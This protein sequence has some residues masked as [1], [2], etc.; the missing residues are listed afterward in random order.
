MK[1]IAAV[2]ACLLAAWV[3]VREDALPAQHVHA[4]DPGAHTHAQHEHGGETHTHHHSAVDA[5]LA[6]HF[7]APSSRGELE[8]L[9]VAAEESHHGHGVNS[10]AE[11]FLALLAALPVAQRSADPIRL[12]TGRH[13]YEWVSEWCQ[14]PADMK[15]GNT[16]GA[17]LVN[18]AGEVLF[19][20]DSRNAVM[21]FER[22]GRYLRSFAPECAG[23]AHG[24]V[25]TRETDSEILWLAHTG[26]HEVLKLDRAGKVLSTLAWP[27]ASGHYTKKEEFNPTSVAVAPDGSIFVADGY[28]R[29]W[30]HRY[31]AAGQWLSAFGGPGAEPG[32]MHTPHG[33]LLDTRTTPPT[34]LV[35][36]RE[37]HR[38]QRFDLEGKFMSVISGDLRRPCKMSL[39]E[40]DIAVADLAGRVTILDKDGKLVTHLGDQPDEALR[41]NNGVP[42]EKWKDG[43]FLAPHGLSFDSE[44]NLYIMDWLS[45]GRVTKL[46]RV[47]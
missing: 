10:N 15:L 13:T 6:R 38:L 8:E 9:L 30:V 17:V 4:H 23:G 22:G 27:E 36:D 19:N 16:H 20:T 39:H 46:Q 1:A 33:L 25:T 5:E 47:K 31:S 12:G 41:A 32:R 21:A 24:M 43:E 42:R 40:S 35:A 28:G 11:S 34:L 37:N 18:G 7:V 26:R 29:S 3:C 2:V 45:L 44:G 14:L